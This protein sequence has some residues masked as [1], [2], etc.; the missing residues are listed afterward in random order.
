[1]WDAET[2]VTIP[3]ELRASDRSALGV[4]GDDT[5]LFGNPTFDESDSLV[6]ENDTGVDSE[7]D[8]S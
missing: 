7:F 1:M 4:R 8:L 6:D 2:F 3:P 5:D